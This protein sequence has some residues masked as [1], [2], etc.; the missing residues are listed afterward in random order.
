MMRRTPPPAAR[1]WAWATLGLAAIWLLAPWPVA[2]GA[3]HGFLVVSMAPVMD[4][5]LT[6]GC[7]A[8]AAGWLVEASLRMMP[9]L[10]GTAWADLSLVLL[11][12]A[13]SR[14]WPPDGRWAYVARLVPTLFLQ[15]ILVH[16]AMALAN[17]GHGW[18][19][20]WIWSAASGLLWGPLAWTFHQ[21]YRR[22]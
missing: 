15:G 10:G 16:G 2:Q 11:V 1:P 21:T 6:A 17:G 4:E 9:H 12:R 20:A 7:W 13:A 18:G 8:I 3:V 19:S 14:M 22:R 5:A